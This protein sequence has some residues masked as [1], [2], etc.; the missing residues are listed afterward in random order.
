[1]PETCW[2]GNA[3]LAP[4]GG[5]YLRCAECETLVD[6][7]PAKEA[8]L[9]DFYGRA[10]WFEHQQTEL[11]LPDLVQRARSDL[12]ERNLH[13]LKTVLKL[14]L[15][16]ADL[17]E[18]GSSHGGFT[19][20]LRWAGFNAT[21]L[22]VDAWVVD[23]ARQT[24][25]VPVLQGALESQSLP[26]GSLD[27]VIL[28]DVLEHLPD[29]AGTLARALE[30]L[31]P[32]GF[33]LLQ[34]PFYPAGVTFDELTATHHPFL[35]MLLPREHIYLFSQAAARRLFERLGAA[36]LRF[37][38]ALFKQHDMFLAASRQELA[39]IAPQEAEKALAKAEQRLVLALLDLEGQYRDLQQH[40]EEVEIDRTARLDLI[41]RQEA[42]IKSLLS[43][44]NQIQEEMRWLPLRALR[45]LRRL[46]LS[47]KG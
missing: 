18:I 30:L 17:L 7:T 37:E 31:R 5:G 27:G 21:G 35:K 26:D 45:R 9:S 38:D 47:R 33:I 24:F 25:D 6:A 14:R 29:P 8:A 46:L 34:T 11:G 20:L 39:Q 13:W 23:F 43:Q 19:A 3:R 22:E 15:P 44:L 28:M 36:H 4:Y 16:P 41:N 1:M 32:Q 10:Y 42:E 12:T 40:L 2:C